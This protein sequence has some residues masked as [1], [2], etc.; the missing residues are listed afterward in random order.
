MR[1]ANGFFSV[2]LNPVTCSCGLKGDQ[3]VHKLAVLLSNRFEVPDDPIKEVN[4]KAL[5]KKGK[6]KGKKSGKK[7]HIGDVDII[8]APDSTASTSASKDP[9]LFNSGSINRSACEK[10]QKASSSSYWINPCKLTRNKALLFDDR[11]Y[12][13]QQKWICDRIIDASQAIIK[14][15]YKVKG[16]QS[17]LFAATPDH[18]AKQTGEWYQIINTAPTSGGSHWILL[19]TKNHAQNKHEF[20]PVINIY[21]SLG[22]TTLTDTTLAAIDSIMHAPKA[23]SKLDSRFMKCDRQPNFDDC[24]VHAISNL[25]MILNDFDLAR[26]T[27]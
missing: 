1:G 6:G 21:D 27:Y 23:C 5:S 9:P 25:V 14:H 19:T 16:L 18:F 2:N 4:L 11:D 22:A 7:K 26:I 12:I 13:G 15:R 10:G 8:P 24:G 17:T 3:C 20:I